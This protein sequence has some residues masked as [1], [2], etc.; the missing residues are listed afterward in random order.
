MDFSKFVIGLRF[1]LRENEQQT[2][3]QAWRA[4]FS[5]LSA[6]EAADLV[7]HQCVMEQDGQ[8]P[9]KTLLCVLSNMS[10]G[11]SRKV[12]ARL[13]ANPVLR[14]CQVLRHE[15][16]ILSNQAEEIT[17][18]YVYVGHVMQDGKVLDGECCF[19]D[20]K[21]HGAEPKKTFFKKRT[22]K[23]LVAANACCD[24]IDA[25]ETVRVMMRAADKCKRSVA[26][27]PFPIAQTAAEA[28]KDAILMRGGRYI[29]VQAGEQIDEL[30]VYCGLLPDRTVA[31]A[32]ETIHAAEIYLRAAYTK[33]YRNFWLGLGTPY[34][35]ETQSLLAAASETMPDAKI[36][37]LDDAMDA[38]Q[39][40][41]L[42]TFERY[43]KKVDAVVSCMNEAADIG[44]AVQE[45]CRKKGKKYSTLSIDTKSNMSVEEALSKISLEAEQAFSELLQ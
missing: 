19:A 42:T 41:E 12:Y 8:H 32:T 29:N 4:I 22:F 26:C 35:A 6:K 37:L 44:F 11:R 5:S 25:E 30:P 36:V 3:E 17:V 1:P 23:V 21:F 20:M 38:E 24:G 34:P 14:S 2:A 16:Y 18:P 33:G 28:I 9:E 45:V 31:L 43:L 40:L 13:T 15:P 39:Y 10:L 27:I 7:L